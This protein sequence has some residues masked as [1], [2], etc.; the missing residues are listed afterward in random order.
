LSFVANSLFSYYRILFLIII[1]L[2]C[3]FIFFNYLHIFL[4]A[5]NSLISI[6]IFF[7]LQFSSSGYSSG[8]AQQKSLKILKRGILLKKKDILAGWQVRFF[9]LQQGRISYYSDESAY[10]SGERD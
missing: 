7:L 10:R 1:I 3:F 5:I 8:E 6:N 2:A 4:F 9:V